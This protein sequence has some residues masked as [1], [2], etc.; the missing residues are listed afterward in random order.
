MDSLVIEIPAELFAPAESSSYAGELAISSF[1]F[2]PDEYRVACPLSWNAAI[3]NVGGALLVSGTVKGQVTT[4]CA[5]CLEDATFDV[6]GEIEGYFLIEGEGEAPDDM[7]ED[8]FD[9][10]PEDNKLD[11]EPLILAA[12]YV[13]LPLIPLCRE[14]CKG[15]CPT[16]G[17][18]LNEGPC[19]CVPDASDE[20]D[21]INSNNPFAAL[22][23]LKLD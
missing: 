20:D 19:G 12:V 21:G 5:R 10:L 14:D 13:E 11:L 17:A 8:E 23:G 4:A 2:G 3:T 15:I 16:C 9:V 6:E 22:K 18:N 1:E 7:E